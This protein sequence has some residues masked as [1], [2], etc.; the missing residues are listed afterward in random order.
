MF[1]D[2]EEVGRNRAPNLRYP[3]DHFSLVCDFDILTDGDEMSKQ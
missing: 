2:G 3:S 1:P